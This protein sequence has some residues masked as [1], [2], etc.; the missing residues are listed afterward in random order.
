MNRLL[1]ICITVFN[2]M[3]MSD[4]KGSITYEQ[5]QKTADAVWKSPPLSMDITYCV[6]LEDSTKTDQDLIK[7]YEK[8]YDQMHGPKESLTPYLLQER[9]SFVQKNVSRFLKEQQ[10]G[11][12]KDTFR[13]RFDEKCLRID[14]SDIWY[15]SQSILDSNIPFQSFSIEK[16][17]QN[18]F[19]KRLEYSNENKSFVTR[20]IN[21]REKHDITQAPIR[22]FTVMPNS[23]LLKKKLGKNTKI[24]PGDIDE[25]DNAKI[26]QLCSDKLE[27]IKINISPDKN[28]PDLKDKIEISIY[29]KDPNKQP[30]KFYMV[31][32]KKDYSRVY[33]DGFLNPKTD[34]ILPTRICDEFDTQ[35]YPHKVI[36]YKYNNE[37]KITYRES[38]LVR[39]VKINVLIPKDVFAFN[40]PTDCEIV[41]YDT[42]LVPRIVREKGGFE[43]G[44]QQFSK[45][46]K[47]KDIGTLK[48]LL[49]H[50]NWKIRSL[51]LQ[52]L[53]FL[54]AQN[55]DEL[56]SL[57]LMLIN[58][59][60]QSVRADAQNVL[61]HLESIKSSNIQRDSLSEPNNQPK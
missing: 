28:A 39:D 22:N 55:P 19:V 45:A 58:D 53:K 51:S 24:S 49:S 54:L 37:G 2:L 35:G 6:S 4:A 29:S 56:K 7:M 17:D 40:P 9:E 38:Y 61:K 52:T 11:G 60:N 20:N 3:H 1:I 48:M 41:E 57:A 26:D 13:I 30:I 47:E 21:T 33:Y 36:K 31:C 42:N 34:Q 59:P 10:E 27:G 14:K 32:D 18:N 8:I 12:K 44:I 23:L 16:I 5:A 15:C 43:G 50:E 25:V 46:A